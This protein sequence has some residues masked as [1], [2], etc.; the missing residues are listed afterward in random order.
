[1]DSYYTVSSKLKCLLYKVH[2]DTVSLSD[3]DIHQAHQIKIGGHLRRLNRGGSRTFRG[4]WPNAKIW[5]NL[6]PVAPIWPLI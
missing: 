4:G 5:G 2:I 6:A 3:Q 1:M